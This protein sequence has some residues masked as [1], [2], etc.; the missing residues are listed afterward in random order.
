MRTREQLR[1]VASSDLHD[2]TEEFGNIDDDDIPSNTA[3]TAHQLIDQHMYGASKMSKQV[4][5]K[6]LPNIC[7]LHQVYSI[8][9]DN[10][11]VD[12]EL[13]QEIRRGRW[14]KFH[15]LGTM[16]DEYALMETKNYLA[17]IQEAKEEFIRE[18]AAGINKEGQDLDSAFFDRFDALVQ[19]PERE[20]DVTRQ[21]LSRTLSEKEVSQLCIY[22]LL[23]PHIQKDTYHFAIRRQGV[24]MSNYLKGRLE[25]VR[26]LKRR[27]TKDILEKLLKTKR[28]RNTVF[29]HDFLLHDL[30]G[31]GRAERI[32]A[33]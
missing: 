6:R 22:G 4:I 28:L 3:I 29:T 30:V 13:A 5:E 11:T 17:V 2:S 24:Y 25:L 12:R 33:I 16:D 31:S 14:R 27:P 21:S 23:I 7:F 15:V 26:M 20:T 19:G 10:T 8:L 18:T 9:R 32:N 1:N